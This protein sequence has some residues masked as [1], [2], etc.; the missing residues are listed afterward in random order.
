MTFW[1][2]IST[3][4]LEGSFPSE[5][6][7]WSYLKELRDIGILRVWIKKKVING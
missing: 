6:E 2:V 5:A 7:A 4:G 3:E 1:L